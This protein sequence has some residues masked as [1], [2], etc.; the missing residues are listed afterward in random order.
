[1]DGWDALI[2]TELEVARHAAE[3]LTTA[4]VTEVMFV[5]PNTVK[6]HPKHAHTKLDVHSRVELAVVVDEHDRGG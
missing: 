2:P 3:G 4:E 6:T 5:S 1:M